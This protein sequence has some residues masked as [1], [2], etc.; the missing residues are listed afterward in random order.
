MH[1]IE[2]QRKVVCFLQPNF[3]D[4]L[5]REE[6]GDKQFS[7]TV[8]YLMTVMLDLHVRVLHNNKSDQAGPEKRMAFK[9]FKVKM[10]I[11]TQ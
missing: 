5:K 10:R 2:A 7:L 1:E 6:A 9:V 11:K 4:K 3:T 8:R